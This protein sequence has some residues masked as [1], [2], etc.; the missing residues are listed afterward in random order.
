MGREAEINHWDKW[1]SVFVIQDAFGYL[2]LKQMTNMMPT[3]IA[4]GR[5]VHLWQ[6]VWSEGRRELVSSVVL[7]VV[8]FVEWFQSGAFHL[9]ISF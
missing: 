7:L 3:S 9:L 6:A 8:I 5:L 1:A 2:L 4:G